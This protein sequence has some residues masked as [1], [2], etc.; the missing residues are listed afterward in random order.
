MYRSASYHI[1]NQ[2]TPVS[3]L[4]A[5]RER[6]A[7]WLARQALAGLNPR[8]QYDVGERDT[9]PAPETIPKGA[10]LSREGGEAD[11]PAWF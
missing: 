2:R 7:E 4:A 5:I 10:G 11:R 3:L 6:L 1:E 9:R 8:R